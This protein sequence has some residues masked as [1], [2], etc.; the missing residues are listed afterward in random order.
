MHVQSASSSS[1]FAGDRRKRSSDDDDD[2]DGG[3]S[4]SVYELSAF[5]RRLSLR[6]RST[7]DGLLSPSFVVQHVTVN[8]TWLTPPRDANGSTA[9]RWRCFHE[10]HVDTDPR[11]IVVLSTCPHLVTTR[12]LYTSVLLRALIMAALRSRCG[13]YIFAL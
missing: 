10:G 11:S 13:H 4:W 9:D 2:V 7:T 5:G 12:P 6:L 1:T 3:G 8:E